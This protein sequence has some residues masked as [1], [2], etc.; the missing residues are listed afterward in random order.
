MPD[1]KKEIHNRLTGLKLEPTRENEIVEELSQHLESLYEELRADSATAEEACRVLLEELTDGQLLAQQ[2]RRAE[3]RV[4]REPVAFDEKKRNMLTDLLQDLRFAVRMLR[5]NPGFTLVAMLSL[6]LGIGGNAAMFSLVNNALIRPLPYSQPDRLVRVTEWYPKGAV[7]ALQQ[8]SRTMDVSGFTLDSQFNLSGQGEAAHLVGSSVSANLFSL[9]GAQAEIGRTFEASEDRPGQDRIVILS[10]ALWQNK[11]AGDTSII[12][13]LITIDGITR[14]VVGVMPKDFSFPSPNTKIWIPLHLD[15]NNQIEFW[16]HG[17][18]PLIARLRQGATIQQSQDEIRSLIS[19][20]IPTFPFPMASNWNAN[21]AVIPLQQNMVSDIQSKLLLLVCA[22]GFV[23]LIACA[24]V[25]SLLLARTAARQREI[26]IRA[27]LGAGRGRIVRQLLTESVALAIAG[28]GIGLI[29][30]FKGLSVLK[31]VLPLDNSRLIEANIDWRVLVFATLLALLTGLVFGLAPALSAGRL[32]LAESFKTRGQQSTGSGGIRLRSSLIVGEVALAV[33]L[34]IGAGLLIKSLWLLMKVNP[35]F[36]PER[37]L[38]VEI[39]PD[40]SSCQQRAECVALYDELLRRA[41]GITGIADVAAANTLPLSREIPAIPVELEGHQ[42]IP[43]ENSAPMFWAGA[44]TPDYFRV[45][46]IPILKGRA[47]N[48]ADGE[49][50]SSVVIIDAATALHF[51][52]DEDPIGKHI[53]PVWDQQWRTV[54]GVVGNVRQYRLASESSEW[55]GGA[56][57]MPYA[58][59]VGLDRQLPAAM[60]LILQTSLTPAQVSSDVRNL[61]SSLNPNLPVSE[62]RN[63]EAIVLDST[64]QSR[65]LMWLFISFGGSALLLAAVGT[66]GIV[67]YSTAQRTHEIGVRV[68]LGATR[69]NIFGLV[70]RQ[71]LRLVLAGL[72]LGIPASLALARMMTGFI[73]GVTATD[74]TTFV[75]VSVL[76]VA[77][78][79]LAGYFPAR[80]AAKVDPM[81]ALRSE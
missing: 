46:Q 22:V 51:W 65:S 24:N 62:I 3:S 70:L 7:V 69:G 73:Y 8:Q 76:L 10:H 38:A 57:Y 66:Y 49:K 60:N 19:Q 25:A 23:L 21:A 48:D 43:A 56:F 44:I 52:P 30:S 28:G 71:S 67:S 1:W 11:F 75:A 16:G 41:R 53:K 54:V 47:F 6:A 35:G 5:K 32:N 79:L 64:S 40:Q 55:L 18:M 33:V 74:P 34:V 4:W 15:P 14:Q 26:A 81:I 20:I 77:I 37:I 50:S 36:S 45:M 31:S 9:L 59:S 13:R 58:Q 17:Y 2:L 72:A 78:A 39:Y 12:G 80:R 42:L 63:L 61:V 29:L 27:A 68:A